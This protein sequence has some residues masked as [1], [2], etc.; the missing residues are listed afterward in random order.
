MTALAPNLG[1]F[2]NEHLPV[3]C[4]AS[5]HTCDTYAYAFQLLVCF[6]ARRLGTQPSML[7]IEQLEAPHILEFLKYIEIERH[8]SPKT[9]NARLAAIKAFFRF[10][11]YRMV[12]CLEQSRSIHAIPMKKSDD[13]LINYLTNDEIQVLLDAPSTTSVSGLRDRAMLNPAFA[14]GL[15]VSE[16]VGLQLQNIV[17][18]P[19]PMIHVV[20]KGRRERH[21][22]LWKETAA[23]L[24]TW[25]S[26]RGT[27]SSPEFFLN[28]RGIGLS[29]SGFEYI[30]AKHVKAVTANAP[31]LSKK[32]HLTTCAAAFLRHAHTDGHSRCT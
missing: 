15:R 27:S 21:L 8:N 18:N 30:L 14:A 11:E 4:R 20:G 13:K 2:L 12:S 26:V 29:R 10:L 25:L 32:A 24:R 19:Q 7:E 16:L 22:P 6:L 28:A 3:E 23:V 5:P 17:L 9:R 31:T 1:I